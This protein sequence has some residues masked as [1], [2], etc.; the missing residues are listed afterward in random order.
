MQ[1]EALSG[2]DV[3]VAL[4]RGLEQAP[5]D[6]SEEQDGIPV[7]QPSH[8]HPHPDGLISRGQSGAQVQVDGPERAVVAEAS[9]RG[10]TLVALA[11]GD[12][13]FRAHVEPHEFTLE[14]GPATPTT[15]EF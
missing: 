5:L 8:L 15:S 2:E 7:G 11:K 12:M 9:G 10:C 1:K 4:D 3:A 6:I 13:G 14:A